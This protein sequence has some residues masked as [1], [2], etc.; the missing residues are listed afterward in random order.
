MFAPESIP[1]WNVVE[2][3]GDSATGLGAGDSTTGLGTAGGDVVDPPVPLVEPEPLV[4]L[5]SIGLESVELEPLEDE[6]LVLPV[7]EPEVGGMAFLRIRRR[8]ALV[9]PTLVPCASSRAS[10]ARLLT[11]SARL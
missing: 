5:E 11:Q 8:T 7:E 6:E 9:L 2:G 1:G 4:K 3:A 10:S